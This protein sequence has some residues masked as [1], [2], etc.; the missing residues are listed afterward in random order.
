[1]RAADQARVRLAL[2]H[3]AHFGPLGAPAHERLARMAELLRV[4]SGDRLDRGGATDERLWV[5]V[6][7]AVRLSVR[8]AEG[9]KEHVHAVLGRGSYFG[10][11]SAVGQGP[12]TIEARAFGDTDLAVID[13]ARLREALDADPRGWKYVSALMSERGRVALGVI[14]DNR[15]RA[16]P[17]RIARRLLGHALSSNLAEGSQ[18]QLRMTQA[19]LARMV[20]VARSRLN[21]VLKRMEGDG[22]LKAG[23]RTITILDL[24]RLRA[25]GGPGVVA[26]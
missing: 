11:A 12:L 26:F 18:P 6:D 22:L 21:P 24:G 15:L 25:L 2:M 9:G 7:G 5:V 19:D 20:D 16:L 23:Y 8:P 10:L 14:E 1:M 4:H 17:E 13:G 3:S